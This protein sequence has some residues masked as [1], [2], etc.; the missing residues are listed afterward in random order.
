MDAIA[1]VARVSIGIP[2]VFT[3]LAVITLFEVAGW[4]LRELGFRWDRIDPPK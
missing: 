2:V 3:V 4:C 1:R